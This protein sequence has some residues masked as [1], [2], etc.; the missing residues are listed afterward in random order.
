MFS[1]TRSS[2]LKAILLA[3][4]FICLFVSCKKYAI[5]KQFPASLTIVN[6]INDNSSVL[7]PYF[8]EDRPKVFLKLIR[9]N[10]GYSYQ[11]GTEKTDQPLKLFLNNDTLPKDRPIVDERIKLEAGEIYTHF[12]YG[13]ATLPKEKTIKES[14]PGYSMY[15]SVT[16]LRIIN[17]FENRSIDIVQIEPTIQTL[18][19]NLKYEELTGFIRLPF[20]SAV[21]NLQFEIRDH[22]TGIVLTS[23]YAPDPNIPGLQIALRDWLYRSNT[24]TVTG[25]WNDASS[26][27]AK[28]AQ[29]RHF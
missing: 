20:T 14:I 4:C 9:L 22:V 11:Y 19:S 25:K 3:G 27:N 18:A 21:T 28:A 10:S 8:G 12:I 13:S 1:F 29:V 15:D 6:A 17:L 23:F 16:N 7:S 2:T 5:E 24:L 26:F